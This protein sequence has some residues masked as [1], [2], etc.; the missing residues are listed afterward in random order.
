LNQHLAALTDNVAVTALKVSG[1]R[2]INNNYLVLNRR[3]GQALLVDPA[4][5]RETVDSALKAANAQLAG[6]LLTHAHADH[7][8]LADTLA[9]EHGCPVW[10]SRREAASSGFSI[11]ALR[12]F[13]EQPWEAAGMLVRPIITPGHTPGSACYWIGNHLFTGDTLFIEGCGLCPDSDAA[14][15]MYSSIQRLKAMLPGKVQIYP[16]HSYVQ[17][18]GLTFERLFR[19]N[20]YLSFDNVEAFIKFRL[21]PG[22]AKSRWM[23]FS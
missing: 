19:Y 21:R 17:P 1:G 10:I 11:A 18:P 3:T 14:S 23:A 22:Q 6:I 8:D 9:N 4:W 20:V 13:D 16:G 7:I 12:T 5:E 15:R 2:F